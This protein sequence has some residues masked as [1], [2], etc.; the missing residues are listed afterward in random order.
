[1]VLHVDRE[2]VNFNKIG[3][4]TVNTVKILNLVVRLKW[5]DSNSSP[6]NF[7]VKKVCSETSKMM[8]SCILLEGFLAD[9]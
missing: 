2:E 9:D 7:R 6:Y 3:G 4:L 8:L 5:F 1:M